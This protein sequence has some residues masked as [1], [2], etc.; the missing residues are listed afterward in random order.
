[1][2]MYKCTYKLDNVQLPNVSDIAGINASRF[3]LFYLF[4]NSLLN[5]MVNSCLLFLSFQVKGQ[6]IQV[7]P[8]TAC[9]DLASVIASYISSSKFWPCWDF[10]FIH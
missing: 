2:G 3:Y 7:I 4:Q 6:Y 1:M 5:I 9:L 8:T 10:I